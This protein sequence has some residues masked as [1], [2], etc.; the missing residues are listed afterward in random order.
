MN[1]AIFWAAGSEVFLLVFLRFPT[2]NSLQI[3]S[4]IL[5]ISKGLAGTNLTIVAAF[6]LPFNF[7]N[8][9]HPYMLNMVDGVPVPKNGRKWK[10]LHNHGK[11]KIYKLG[12][13]F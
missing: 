10:H 3:A 5:N 11:G 8:S 12:D 1:E 9:K 13:L 7:E 2:V 4:E 6:L